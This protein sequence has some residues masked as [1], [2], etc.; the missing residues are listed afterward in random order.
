MSG[1]KAALNFVLFQLGWFA[2]V[3]SAAMHAPLW[4]T[5]AAL[6]VVAV[7]LLLAPEPAREVPL[8]IAAGLLGA[9]WES[10]AVISGWFD[11][12]AGML[13]AWLAPHWI[14]AMWLMFA[15]TLNA[16]LAWLKRN[17]WLAAVCGAAFAPPAY[18][19]GYRLGAVALPEVD[20][21]LMAQSLAWALLLPLL[22]FL[23]LQLQART[24]AA[25]AA[26]VE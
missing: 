11:Y 1:W 15:T 24:P 6:A 4:G 9:A 14:I 17:L 12:S 22:T 20:T 7:H 18:Y 3:F 10:L 26:R 16:S 25:V 13:H 19:A 5:A 23:A 2:C 8:I 21:A